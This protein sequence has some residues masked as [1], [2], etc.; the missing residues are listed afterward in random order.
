MHHQPAIRQSL[1]HSLIDV[2][3]ADV[4]ERSLEDFH[5]NSKD[6]IAC[7]CDSLKRRSPVTAASLGAGAA[8]TF[9]FDNV[10]RHDKLITVRKMAATR[11]RRLFERLLANPACFRPVL[12]IAHSALGSTG[13]QLL[14]GR[15]DRSLLRPAI[16]AAHRAWATDRG[17]LVSVSDCRIGIGVGASTRRCNVA[18]AP[19]SDSL[20]TPFPPRNAKRFRVKALQK[21][22]I[23]PFYFSAAVRQSGTVIIAFMQR[24]KLQCPIPSHRKC[25]PTS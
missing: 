16:Q 4:L 3:V 20:S 11:V 21:P 8:R 18:D 14:P 19:S 10:Y 6:L 12:S 5:R 1:V 17:R 9:L 2:Q 15:Y 23:Q 25:Y 7:R 13:R 22:Q 24:R